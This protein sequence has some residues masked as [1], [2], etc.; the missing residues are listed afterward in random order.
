MRRAIIAAI[1]GLVVG[2]V[3]TLATIEISGGRYEYFTM[4]LER[5]QNTQIRDEV[6]PNQPNPCHF[7]TARW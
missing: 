2:I 3:V 5:C 4:P 6:V 1:I 7:R